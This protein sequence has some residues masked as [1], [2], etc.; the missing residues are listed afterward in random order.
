[1]SSNEKQDAVERLIQAVG[2]IFRH[3]NPGVAAT[4]GVNLR[5][6][7]LAAIAAFPEVAQYV[8]VGD[9]ARG[10]FQIYPV[11]DGM[12]LAYL[13][14]C[15]LMIRIREGDCVEVATGECIW[16]RLYHNQPMRVGSYV[17]ELYRDRADID[18]NAPTMFARASAVA[19]AHAP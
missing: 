2:L 3:I 7:V 19:S 4:L 14:R 6:A 8:A 18:R 17:V 10:D 11:L 5:E 13:M 15:P 12:P 9:T 1:M 16:S